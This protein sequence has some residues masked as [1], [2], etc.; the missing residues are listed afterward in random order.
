MKVVNAHRRKRK[1]KEQ[2][3]SVYIYVIVCML[4]GWSCCLTWRR[5]LVYSVV[6]FGDRPFNYCLFLLIVVVMMIVIM[7]IRMMISF[8]NERWYVAFYMQEREW[9]QWHQVVIKVN[10]DPF[11]SFCLFSV[12]SKWQSIVS[13]FCSCYVSNVDIDFVFKWNNENLYQS[14]N[15][16]LSS[17][18]INHPTVTI[19][20]YIH[21]DSLIATKVGEVEQIR[22][23]S[24]SSL[25]LIEQEERQNSRIVKE[26]EKMSFQ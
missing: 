15:F 20:T 22:A 14:Y 5:R 25:V 4:T 12:Y 3:K 13:W 11:S 24:S 1:K 6:S 16:F 7:R 19:H 26:R 8:G 18:I 9:V 2:K 17:Y 21:A 10:N 23:S